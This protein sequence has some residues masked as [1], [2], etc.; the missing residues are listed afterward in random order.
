MASDDDPDKV[1]RKVILY[2][3]SDLGIVF[4]S[5]LDQLLI[6]KGLREVA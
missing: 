6:Q 2:P 3:T 1:G 5:V 4:I